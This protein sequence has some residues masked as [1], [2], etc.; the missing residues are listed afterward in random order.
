[1]LHIYDKVIGEFDTK[2]ERYGATYTLVN[3][4]KMGEDLYYT[5]SCPGRENLLVVPKFA[6]QYREVE[7]FALRF[8]YCRKLETCR[9]HIKENINKNIKVEKMPSNESSTGLM[10]V[11][12]AIYKDIQVDFLYMNNRMTLNPEFEIIKNN[13]FGDNIRVAMDLEDE[14]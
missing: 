8:A 4:T 3:K 10:Y 13:I 11:I 5:F 12:T 2:L 6:E 1:M 7:Q 14:E 9:I